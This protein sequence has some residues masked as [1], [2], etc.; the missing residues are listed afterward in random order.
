MKLVIHCGLH[1]TATTS[2]QRLCAENRA[3]L[4]GLGI[5]YPA[6][7]AENQHSLILHEAQRDGMAVLGSYFARARAEAGAECSTVLISGEDFEN[8]IADVALACDVE[9][10]A[11]GAGFSSVTW[12]VVTRPLHESL[13]SLY[14]ELSKHGVVLDRQTIQRAAEERG[15]FHVTTARFNHVFI[16]D[17]PRFA[18]RFRRNLTGDVAEFGLDAF[19]AGYPGRVLLKDLLTEDAHLQFERLAVITATRQNPRLGSRQVEANYLATALGLGI[20][21]HAALRPLIGPFIW[22]RMRK[23]RRTPNRSGAA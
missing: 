21:R 9:T 3:L 2:F 13:G 12:A 19:V 14:A 10:L 8:C 18:A 16:L 4:R 1:K 11:L 15:C 7:G 22:L 23:A 6:F 17:F 5:H 20:F